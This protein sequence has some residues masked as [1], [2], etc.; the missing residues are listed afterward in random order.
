[1]HI[2]YVDDERPA[3]ENFRFTVAKI[4]EIK[5]L[6]MFQDGEEAME[7]VQKNTID[8]AF[9]DMEM[10]GIHGLE[11]AKKLKEYDEE[12]RVIFVTAYGQY[13]LE[14][15]GVDATGYLMK[16][17]TIADIR[18]ELSKCTYR[19]LP[20]HQVTIQTIPSFGLFVNGKPL[21]ISASKPKELLALLVDRGDAGITTSEAI[22]CLWPERPDNSSSQSLFRMTYKR[23]V[24]ILEDSGIAH[25]IGSEGACRFIRED[26]VDCDL[27]RIFHGDKQTARSYG[28]QY[29]Q[30]YSWA[31]ERNGQLYWMLLGKENY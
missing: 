4:E 26:Q 13:A 28:G 23:L 29:L 14:A 18:K 25:I 12:I 22:A 27:Y 5:S 15:F 17:Y 8:V 7:Y 21:R 9:L 19:R 30:E 6:E 24:D 11:L 1:M 16:P 31:E 20:S 2:I 3:L 10:P